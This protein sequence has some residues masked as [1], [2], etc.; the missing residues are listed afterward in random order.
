MVGPPIGSTSSSGSGLII[1]GLGEAVKAAPKKVGIEKGVEVVVVV[2]V[3]VV[4]LV[5]VNLSKTILASKL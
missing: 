1:G 2:V 5:E 3:V 4:L